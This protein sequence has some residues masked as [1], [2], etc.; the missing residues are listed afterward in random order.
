MTSPML[1]A[2]FLT[3]YGERMAMDLALKEALLSDASLSLVNDTI[4]IDGYRVFS[5]HDNWHLTVPAAL[6]LLPP[7]QAYERYCEAVRLAEFQ[8]VPF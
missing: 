1:R 6:N 7:S 4:T 5:I 3:H 2:S 8:G